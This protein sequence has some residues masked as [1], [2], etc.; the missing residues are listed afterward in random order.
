VALTAAGLGALYVALVDFFSL[1]LMLP[2]LF[3]LL[4]GRRSGLGRILDWL[5][6]LD[7][8]V[9]IYLLT[10]CF[11]FQILRVDLAIFWY[12]MMMISVGRG[13]LPIGRGHRR[14]FG[15]RAVADGQTSLPIEQGFAA[16]RPGAIGTNALPN[17]NRD[18]CGT[19]GA[20]ETNAVRP[21]QMGTNAVRPAQSGRMRYGRRNRDECG[22]A[23]ANG[24]ECAAAALELNQ[25][26]RRVHD[27]HAGR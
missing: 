1:L 22:T 18:E 27:Q 10:Y 5:L 7:G 12:L 8:G 24:D 19:A 14:A 2:L 11:G 3:W 4:I 13:Q 25:E 26:G 6:F 16:C 20:I 15:G 23:G 9:M 17:C 21:A